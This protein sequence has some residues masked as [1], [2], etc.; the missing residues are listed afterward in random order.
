[1]YH[2]PNKRRKRAQ[3]A[4]IYSLMAL[5]VILI[6][7]AL[8]LIIQGY[9]YNRYDGKLEQGGL[10]QFNSR[11]AGASV[12]VD[13]LTLANRTASK[14][15]LT[16]GA[17]TVTI[18]RE[19]Y[20]TWKKT[21]TVKPG[22]VLWL[23]YAQLLPV[24]L[25][26]TTAATYIGATTPLVTPNHKELAL[27][28]AGT[29]PVITMTSLN[30]D[31]PE[32]TK[33]TIPTGVLTAPGEGV[34]SD[35]SLVAWD[36]SNRYLIVK[37]M[38]GDKVEYLSVDT[39]DLA[40]S[41]NITAT[42]GVDISSVRYSVADSGILYILT[43]THELRR[44]NLSQSTLSGPLAA[45]VAE[46]SMPNRDTVIYSTLPD[47]S[48]VRAVGYVSSGLTTS[49]QLM[50]YKNM[51]DTP[52][53]A[54]IG[55]YYGEQYAVISHGEV[56]DIYQGDTPGSDAK[57]AVSLKKVAS[58]TAPGG[59]DYVGFSPGENRFAYAAKGTSILTYDLELM[60]KSSVTLQSSLSRD[61]EW[62]DG[63]HIVTTAG[64]RGYFYDF[65]GTNGQLFTSNSTGLPAVLAD[66]NTY[67]YYFVQTDSDI[68]LQ[69]IKTV[70]E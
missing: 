12:T 4:F 33:L 64:G 35:F 2:A 24:T 27:I 70:T 51:K 7:A 54:S 30:T 69:R 15:T 10:V 9:R 47:E 49:K 39:D 25:K 46:F 11:P 42:L 16:S 18:S 34:S 50:S 14:I 5:A 38:Y 63:Y 22:G 19:G 37:H 3:L 40:R 32:T 57:P 23:N 1:M 53:H 65:D 41:R 26:P 20:T 44:A 43:N 52:V 13:D 66:G 62:M 58:Y 31:K 60:Q 36:T 59:V 21:V 8:I 6:V 55:T 68:R 67:L 29:Q 45:S 56:I 48:G 28:E 17:H 61:V